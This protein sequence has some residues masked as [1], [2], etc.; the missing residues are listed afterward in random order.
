MLPRFTVGGHPDRH[1]NGSSREGEPVVLKNGKP[2]KYP[3]NSV[4][5]AAQ[6]NVTVHQWTTQE[7]KDL[8]TG[9]IIRSTWCKQCG[10]VPK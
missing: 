10:G 2:K 5:P 8:R 9:E 7:G 6:G 4:C 3:V 1:R